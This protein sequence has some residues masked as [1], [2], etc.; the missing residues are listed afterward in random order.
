MPG[1]T[2]R[3]ITLINT[4]PWGTH[5]LTLGDGSSFRTRLYGTQG[6]CPNSPGLQ[7]S[8]DMYRPRGCYQRI[9]IE[10]RIVAPSPPPVLEGAPPLRPPSPSTPPQLCHETCPRTLNHSIALMDRT[11][12]VSWRYGMEYLTT[13][14]DRDYDQPMYNHDSFTQ[15]DWCALPKAVTHGL[16]LPVSLHALI[17]D[18]PQGMCRGLTGS[19]PYHVR[20]RFDGEAGFR[21]PTTAPGFGRCHN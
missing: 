20:Y 4:Y 19:A 6:A 15:A 8:N 7:Q 1:A 9:L 16:S 13:R 11:R 21:M 18:F 2:E 14:C 12:S 3:I 5:C 10:K 17:H